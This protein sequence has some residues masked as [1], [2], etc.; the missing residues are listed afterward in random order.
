MNRKRS[1][2]NEFLDEILAKV[3]DVNYHYYENIEA[4]YSRE[5]VIC[6]LDPAIEFLVENNYIKY[7]LIGS[8][9]YFDITP[10]GIQLEQSGGFSK[11]AKDKEELYKYAKG[12]HDYAR[13]A[14]FVSITGILV[15]V[16]LFALSK[17]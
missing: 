2:E 5:D 8:Q 12:S 14:Y 15:A 17:C 16:V 13:K 4:S 6:K 10:K 9:R 11:A 3:Q 7:R 1:L